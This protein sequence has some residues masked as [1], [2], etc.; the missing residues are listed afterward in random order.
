MIT[1]LR[2]VGIGGSIAALLASV[3]LLVPQPPQAQALRSSH[4]EHLLDMIDLALANHALDY[5]VELGFRYDE[6]C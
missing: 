5:A 6:E 3:A 1:S 4:C 2:T